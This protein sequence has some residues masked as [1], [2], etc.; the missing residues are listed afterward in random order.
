MKIVGTGDGSRVLQQRQ[1]GNLAGPTGF[2]H[3]FVFR[4][5]FIGPEQNFVQLFFDGRRALTPDQILRPKLNLRQD[6]FFLLYARQSQ[7]NCFGRGFLKP[8]L[9]CA[10]KIMRR[11]IQPHEG[12]HLLG[13]AGVGIEIFAGDV[14]KAKLG[15][16]RK[17]P[18]Q[19]KL[20]AL[21][22]ERG[23]RQKLGR[24][25]FLKFQKYVGT[26]DFDPLAA[27]QFHLN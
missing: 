24:S 26:F 2:N 14:G 4:C 22:N 20:N 15:V 27:V 25:W 5:I 23:F 19:I 10:A 8:P 12:T 21:A 1:W 11:L 9:A 18:S 17:F 16:G 6:L 7:L 3:G 13:G